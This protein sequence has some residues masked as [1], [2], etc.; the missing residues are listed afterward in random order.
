MNTPRIEPYISFGG[1]CEEALD[2]YKK[3]IGAKVEMA[4][5]FGE[6][7]EPMPAGALP[8]GFETKI[9]HSSFL[10]GNSRVMASDGCGPGTPITGVSLSISVADEP[11]ADKAFNALAQGGQV[12]MP[13][14]KTFWSP[15]FG[16]VTDKFGLNWMVSVAVDHPC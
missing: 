14:A 10:V 5:R 4:M 9:M 7:P 6:S 8:P 15:K 13:L 2:F 3:A 16:M 11:A 12:T 1:R